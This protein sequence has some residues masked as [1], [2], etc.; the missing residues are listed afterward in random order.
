MA[1]VSSREH[2]KK[3]F[4]IYTDNGRWCAR[5]MDGLVFGIFTDQASALRFV[6]L[7][8]NAVSVVAPPN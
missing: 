6:R 7:E 1:N 3:A 8:G 2:G 5:R 4:E